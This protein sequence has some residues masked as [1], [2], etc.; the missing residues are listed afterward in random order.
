[1]SQ[2]WSLKSDLPARRAEDEDTAPSLASHDDL[3]VWLDKHAESSN[4]KWL[5]A[6]FDDGVLW[7]RIDEGVLRTSTE[8]ARSHSDDPEVRQV[9]PACPE[10]RLIT[11]Q[12]ARLFSEQVELLVW[13]DGDNNFHTRCIENA[14]DENKA[15]WRICYDES[16]LLWGTNGVPLDPDPFTLLWEGT[17]GLRHV[18]PMI[19]NLDDNG[20]IQQSPRLFLR[21]YLNL[22]DEGMA[23][24]VASRLLKIDDKE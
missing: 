4:Y 12:E 22:E 16:Q 24:V 19:V 7:G 10:I 3:N 9:L 15:D 6:H 14:D 8:V 13:R 18:L 11:L 20:Q 1:M 17:Q 2:Y 5:L 23:R 21:H